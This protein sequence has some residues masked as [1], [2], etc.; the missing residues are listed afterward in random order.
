MHPRVDWSEV[1]CTFQ[2]SSGQN[3][4]DDIAL[5]VP[6]KMDTQMIHWHLKEMN[7]HIDNCMLTMKLE[8]I[9]AE[10]VTTTGESKPKIRF[11][12]PDGVGIAG[13]GSDMQSIVMLESSMTFVAVEPGEGLW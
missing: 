10:K 11:D 1:A 2:A 4:R 7:R 5:L 12:D 3:C 6:C 8:A 9:V 13:R